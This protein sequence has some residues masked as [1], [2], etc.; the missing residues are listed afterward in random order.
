[1]FSGAQ[2]RSN[3]DM[4][5]RRQQAWD[6]ATLLHWRRLLD[7]H[8]TAELGLA[9]YP[10]VFCWDAPGPACSPD[11]IAL[12]PHLPLSDSQ[13]NHQERKADLFGR[14]AEGSIDK[15]QGLGKK[16]HE[17]KTQTEHQRHGKHQRVSEK[18]VAVESW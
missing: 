11:T 13:R 2:W 7:R 17:G 18:Y 12:Q 3:P 5:D 16:I 1:M 4:G 9:L 10:A 6:L 15:R 14:P 8:P